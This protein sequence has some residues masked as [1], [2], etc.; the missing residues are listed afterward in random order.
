MTTLAECRQ[1]TRAHIDEQTARFWD[2]TNEIDVWIWEAAKDIARRAE[3]LSDTHTIRTKADQR[4]YDFPPDLLRVHK[5]VYENDD[6]SAYTLDFVPIAQMD[7]YH[8]GVRWTGA[9][10]PSRWSSWGF[11]GD[12]QQFVLDRAPSEHANLVL[13]YYRLPRKPVDDGD[14]VEVPAGWESLIPLYAEMV[15]RRKDNDGRW[16][17]AAALYEKGVAEMM[18]ATRHHSDQAT[19]FSPGGTWLDGSDWD[20]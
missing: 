6:G 16:Q 11:S 2:D 10:R 12:S 13:Y 15:A 20:W 9:G 3:V 17:E 7:D 18:R 19:V 14:P 8:G 4:T 1:Q 5:V